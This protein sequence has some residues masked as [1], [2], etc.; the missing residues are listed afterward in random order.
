[1]IN[2]PQITIGKLLGNPNDKIELANHDIYCDYRKTFAGQ[3]NISIKHKVDQLNSQTY[4]SPLS[5]STT[6]EAKIH[7]DI[8]E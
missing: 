4:I 6:N 8:C 5:T 2:K 1:M 7:F 3:L